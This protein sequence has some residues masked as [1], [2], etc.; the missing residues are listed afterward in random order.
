MKFSA[1]VRRYP[2]YKYQF[3]DYFAGI[4]LMLRAEV[5]YFLTTGVEF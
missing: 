5:Y 4:Q 2:P 1:R 3:Y